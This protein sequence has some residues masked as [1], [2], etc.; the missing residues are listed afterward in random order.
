MAPQGSGPINENQRI[1][2]TH[3][4][5]LLGLREW[6]GPTPHCLL[7]VC[8]YVMMMREV[9]QSLLPSILFVVINPRDIH[10][11]GKDELYINDYVQKNGGTNNSQVSLSLN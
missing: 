10:A 3:F 11:L 1:Q 9:Q 6:K 4:F 2:N 8:V 7:S 5:F